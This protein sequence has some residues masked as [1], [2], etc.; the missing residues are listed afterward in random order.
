MIKLFGY[1]I[2]K[3]FLLLA[4]LEILSFSSSILF[5][6]YYRH[7]SP[8]DTEGTGIAELSHHVALYALSLIHI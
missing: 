3:S 7:F 1:F 6:D 2:S 5:I 4:L 8:S